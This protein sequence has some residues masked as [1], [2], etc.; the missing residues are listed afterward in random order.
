[1]AV[2]NFSGMSARELSQYHR[3]RGGY[4][5]SDMSKA[6]EKA[7]TEAYCYANF[8]D[9]DVLEYKWAINALRT[10]GFECCMAEWHEIDAMFGDFYHFEQFA[11][12]WDKG[13]SFTAK[14]GRVLTL[15]QEA[16]DCYQVFP[17]GGVGVGAIG[18]VR[19]FYWIV[20]AVKYALELQRA[21]YGVVH[22]QK[23]FEATAF[24]GEY[25]DK[26]V[27]DGEGGLVNPFRALYAVE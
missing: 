26:V 24:D 4:E 27:E 18:E 19:D 9:R 11:R 2:K 15:A 5:N 1:M 7:W 23:G 16:P 8:N 13:F 22:L 12:G 17:D 25:D 10:A 14:D 21:E 20:E 6:E 3:A